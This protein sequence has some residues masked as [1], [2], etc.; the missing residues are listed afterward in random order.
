MI[1]ANLLADNEV[2]GLVISGGSEATVTQNTIRTSGTQG[3]TVNTARATIVG[4]LTE[5]NLRNGVF[6]NQNS[7][8]TV[9]H[10]TARQNGVDGITVLR[11]STAVLTGNIST[12]NAGNG[13]S[14]IFG[15]TATLTGNTCSNNG[16]NG[17]MIGSLTSTAPNTV[18]LTGNTIE[19][20]FF[21]GIASF[22]PGT[23][24]LLQ[25]NTLRR[26]HGNGIR[27]S[28]GATA[29]INGG[30]ITLS[31]YVGIHL[32]VGATATI[33]L[34][35][36]AELV[37]SHNVAAGLF[38]DT[39][40][41]AARINSGRVR[42]DANGGGTIVGRVTDVFVDS[43][44]DGLGDADEAT[45]GTDPRRTDT[46]GD[47]LRDGFEVRYGLAPLDLRDGLADSDGDGLT[48]L[49]EQAAGTDPRHPDTD[50]DGLTDGDEVHVYGTDPTRADTD[51]DGLTDGEEVRRY[52]TNSRDPDSDGDGF[53]DGIEVAAG[54]DPR[55]PRN[56]PTAV[57]YGVNVLRND[58]LV[59]NPHTGQ[60]FVLGPPT[61]DPN[62][63]SGAPSTFDALVWSPHS[64]TLY[65][66]AFGFVR[67]L[68]EQRL[69]TLDP[70]TGAILTTVVVT[71]DPPPATGN[72]PG[73]IALG[74]DARGALLAT[75][76]FAG[77]A[78]A[79][80]LGRLDPVTGVLTRLG[81]T[82]FATL[83]GVQ[84]D[85]AFRTLYAVTGAQI[86]P[87]LV[88]LDPATGQG[89]AIA[90]TDLPTQAT[91]LALLADGR[92]VVG[93]DDGNLYALDPVTGASTLIGPTGVEA[94][95]GMSQRVLR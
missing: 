95:S 68:A 46:D 34:D 67:G 86:P 81:P 56:V 42:F 26:N 24:L 74:V 94:V 50:G 2:T 23:T 35:G 54:R 70:N 92:L 37:V 22:V 65:A 7:T 43:D 55:D 18:V 52:G 77:L 20:N 16:A 33:G 66:K 82:G 12:N 44:G 61:G 91:S 47:S 8:A 17:I 69:H 90:R 83:F 87:V 59:L 3:I 62:L 36:A 13:C 89:T 4:N 25:E 15:S 30:L 10:N 85:P 19:D 72:V 29:S 57:L 93:G 73:L 53:P 11:G 5:G 84:F 64:R 58:V 76:S 71:V 88:A 21:H 75:V 63:A 49:E 14:V 38:V 48:N 28:T 1:T 45:R 9:T 31:G 27:L 80:D 78:N 41:S 51:R 79:S 32:S 60:A 6:I 39:D 40:G